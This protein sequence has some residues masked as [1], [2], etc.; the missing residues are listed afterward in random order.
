M[1]GNIYMDIISSQVS[2]GNFG[3]KNGQFG[4]LAKD[5]SRKEK[6]L[7]KAKYSESSPKK[8]TEEKYECDINIIDGTVAEATD[9]N[10]LSDP[11]IIIW[12]VDR[13]GHPDKSLYKSK[14]CKKTLT[15]VWNEIGVFK[16]K[17]SYE[18]LIVELWDHDLLS[19]N[20]FIGRATISVVGLNSFYRFNDKI[21]VYDDKKSTPSGTVTLKISKTSKGSNFSSCV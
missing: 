20:D 16:M 7:S 4:Y 12:S 3:G 15:P 5:K 10:G 18:S 6:K 19:A 9:S 13:D 11:F 2:Q 8:R 21:S 17:P 14:V 1:S